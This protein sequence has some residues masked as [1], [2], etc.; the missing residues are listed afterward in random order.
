MDN[1][2]RLMYET[3]WWFAKKAVSS[4]NVR[5]SKTRSKNATMYT[6]TSLLRRK[7]KKMEKD[8]K[9]KILKQK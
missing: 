1:Q 6:N 9:G 3:Q 5:A 8:K 2:L 7:K 4:R